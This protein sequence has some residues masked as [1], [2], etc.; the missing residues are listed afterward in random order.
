[1]LLCNICE[2]LKS[3]VPVQEWR[4]LDDIT[5]DVCNVVGQRRRSPLLL[6]ED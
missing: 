6:L 5:D 2:Y 4:R 3:D 1:M